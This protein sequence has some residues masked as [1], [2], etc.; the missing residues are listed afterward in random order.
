MKTWTLRILG[1][2]AAL[3]AV[4]MVAASV[5][6]TDERLTG[7]V[8][9]PLKDALGE[10][11]RVGR[12]G[13][14]L[15]RTFP[16]FGLVVEDLVLP[17]AQGDTVLTLGSLRVS[18]AVLPLLG[19]DLQIR[20][21][22]VDR[23]DARYRVA[24]DGSTNL[25]FLFT[26][27]ADT[28]S[29]AASAPKLE[30]ERLEIRAST[31][32]YDDLETD[33][34]MRITGLNLDASIRLGDLIV[35]DVD[36][37]LDGISLSSGGTA[38][39]NSLPIRFR[40]RS[41]L[42]LD[43]ASLALEEGFISI[44]GL[45]LN[46]NGNLS[47]WD[48]DTTRYR[49]AFTS[50]SDDFGAL[51]DLVPDAYK[52]ELKGVVTRGSLTLNGS[53]EGHSSM[54]IPIFD[55][56]LGVDGGYFKHPAAPKAVQNIHIDISATNDR[57]RVGSV[58]A[59]AD[60][61]RVSLTAE[62]TDPFSPDGRF[63]V[64]A[65]AFADLGTLESYYPVSKHGLAIRGV[66]NLTADAS[67]RIDQADRAAFNAA[68]T[69]ADGWMKSA[70][71]EKPIEDIQMALTSTQDRLTLSSLKAR[72]S[73][74]T[75]SVS[76]TVLQP[77]AMDRARFDMT[78]QVRLD[79][80]TL[81]EFIAISE[82]TLTLR[83]R[84]DFDGK[85]AGL[86]SAPES[87]ELSGD[88]KLANVSILYGTPTSTTTLSGGMNAN[89]SFRGQASKIEDMRFTGGLTLN[90]LTLM[91]DGLDYPIRDMNG[92]LVF[93]QANVELKAFTFRMGSSDFDLTGSALNYRNLFEAVGSR[94]P[95][96][97]TA[98]FASKVL[99]VDEIWQYESNDDPLYIDL[100]N[101]ETRLTARIDSLVFVKIPITQVRGR[102]VTTPTYMEMSEA[103]A[104]LFDGGMSGYVKW[105]VLKRD[106]TRVTFRGD[107]T[108]V[109]SET[110]FRQFQLG[111]RSDFHTYV[112]G[113]FTAKTDFQAE[114][115]EQLVQ[116]A[117]T[118]QANG[119]FG[120]D[121]ARL[122]GHPA[123]VK[124]ASLLGISELSDVSLDA[125][126]ATFTIVN[127]LMTL[128]DMRLT[129]KDIGLNLNGTHNLVTDRIDYKVHVT[130][131]GSYGDRM[132]RLLTKDGVEALKNDAGMIVVPIA[133][134][135]TSSNPDV[136]V[137]RDFLQAAI[138]EYLRKK[139]TD[140]A[141]RILRGII[142]N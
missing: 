51:L 138:A 5:Y 101:A 25:D 137:D 11:V 95:G 24:A 22:L 91:T 82:D 85:G 75:I 67:G 33:L 3:L 87:A 8:M 17:D 46:T 49:F 84:F 124:L 9:P 68:L 62:I 20:K 120:M 134:T 30:L 127:G 130:L 16:N 34:R 94:P 31:L 123:Q 96:R 73:T 107:V 35:S 142:R 136:G 103:S 23:L 122:K 74:N 12:L 93:N 69:L 57:I 38:L 48:S 83:G 112:S 131:P 47:G 129:S 106:H 19:G 63:T 59:E 15:F 111:G 104:R 117:R 140:A 141:G 43:A 54:D 64:Q 109:R 114:M 116:D 32:R 18:V 29:S 28:V 39:I 110:F 105:D 76:G 71:V 44:R 77:L 1:G 53:V 132:E 21:V 135:G 26:A 72:A 128:R 60:Q 100:P 81:K 61:N 115:N 88:V 126:T 66:L 118:I 56:V 79:L 92:D 119:S 10:D 121:R 36:G 52:T 13:Y 113:G 86:V 78:G 4:L 27:E 108:N 98:S 37:H 7:L 42:N 6:L 99:N 125:W 50:A 45:T 90:S 58:K 97:L 55:L 80:A 14:T 40:Q 89:L 133:M 65:T 139:G 102:A 41:S 2:I 70:D